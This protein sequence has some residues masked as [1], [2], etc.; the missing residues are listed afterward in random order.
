MFT[1]EQKAKE[2]DRLVELDPELLQR[3][4]GQWRLRVRRPRG[5]S[6]KKGVQNLHFNA[7]QRLDLGCPLPVPACY[8]DRM[9]QNAPRAW[10]EGSVVEDISTLLDLEL[11]ERNRAHT[12]MAPPRIA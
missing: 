2:I 7:E 9:D 6:A 5:S 3:V 11:G 8:L 4:S 1:V 12:P 10:G